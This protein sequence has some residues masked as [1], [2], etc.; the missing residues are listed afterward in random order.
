MLSMELWNLLP[1]QNIWHNNWIL[2]LKI[3]ALTA[4]RAHEYS[5]SLERTTSFFQVISCFTDYSVSIYWQGGP[6]TVTHMSKIWT[7]APDD[8]SICGILIIGLPLRLCFIIALLVIQKSHVF[9][10]LSILQ[11]ISSWVSMVALLNKYR[12]VYND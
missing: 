5:T 6:C 10:T 11:I 2:A 8:V 3:C 7:I 9:A 4:V 1:L 12:V